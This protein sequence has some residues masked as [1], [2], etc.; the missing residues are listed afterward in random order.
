MSIP[1]TPTPKK[2][3]IRDK[4][5]SKITA[6]RERRQNK[7]A[8]NATKDAKKKETREKVEKVFFYLHFRVTF[9]T[10]INSLKLSLMLSI[11]KLFVFLFVST[12]INPQFS[13]KLLVLSE[14]WLI[15]TLFFTVY[16]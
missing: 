15:L 4:I 16:F 5:T 7:K 8:E 1:S 6:A 9:V 11:K 14:L 2:V 13:S 12:C 10:S 3:T